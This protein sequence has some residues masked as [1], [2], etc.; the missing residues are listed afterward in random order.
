MKIIKKIFH[1]IGNIFYLFNPFLTNGKA[2]ML[3]QFFTALI[4]LPVERVLYVALQKYI[5]DSLAAGR[6]FLQIIIGI[7]SFSL[8]MMALE[9]FDS[10][11]FNAYGLK[12]YITIRGLVDKENYKKSIK[13]DYKYFDDPEFYDN[14]T[15]AI[16][17]RSG[18]AEQARLLII[19][20]MATAMTIIS[21]S[22]MIASSKW[23][24]IL[25]IV[26]TF[27]ISTFIS[28]KSME[29]NHQKYL[30]QIPLDRKSGY[31]HQLFY[32]K[33]YAAD[34]KV[35][36]SADFLF[37]HYDSVL[38]DKVELF[39][40]YQFKT[41]FINA[42]SIVIEDL[43]EI[44]IS[45]YLVYL[46]I[47]N[48]LSIG[49]FASML[50]AA[51][52]LKSNKGEFF[53][54]IPRSN[55][56][57]IYADKIKQFYNL[58]SKIEESDGKKQPGSGSFAVEFDNVG[59]KYD[60]SE[61]ELKN[62]SMKIN[63]GD[64][65][66]IVGENGVGKTTLTKLLL[67]LYDVEKGEIR[68]NGTPLPDYDL[69]SVRNRI[70]I[71]SQTPLVYAIPLSE[72]MQLYNDK[73]PEQLTEILKELQLTSILENP[74]VSLSTE[75]TKEFDK[76]GIVLSQGETQKLGLSRLLYGDFGLLILDE[77]S[78]SLDPIAEY[79]LTKMIFNQSNK[80]TTIMIA[81]RLSTIRDAD[82]IFLVDN[83][84]IK[85]H[86]THDELMAK[87]G[88]YYDMFTKQAENYVK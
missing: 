70:G 18:K 30:E 77:P 79:E 59:F 11:F 44:A 32:N 23:P 86:G 46:I 74:N 13:T 50:T 27:C 67:R 10:I 2:Y 64:K 48:E 42:V 65:I 71:A 28:N 53:D 29:I 84:V 40:K 17:E 52:L 80:A 20:F 31:I 87:K 69:S 78:S 38:G 19:R 12:K 62:I 72:N 24:I 7:L 14:Y 75:L 54:L 49:G 5:I 39:K 33:N 68:L 15:Y 81:H 8:G 57:S 35:N 76:D 56:L 22:A 73:S 25:I 88:K 26:A 34:L 85:E 45:I 61:F 47:N 55:E 63:A 16:N 58:P 82:E 66:A 21:I 1:S 51:G 37:K 60:N 36:R 41:V 4:I 9:L 83:G 43:S 6:L 3:G